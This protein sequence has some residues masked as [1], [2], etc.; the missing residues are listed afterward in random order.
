M[1][2]RLFTGIGNTVVD[3]CR[4]YTLTCYWSWFIA[5]QL[6]LPELGFFQTFGIVLGLDLVLK[7][8]LNH[9]VVTTDDNVREADN[10]D[11]GR[12]LFVGFFVTV[13]FLILGYVLSLLQ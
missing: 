11:V 8:D 3:G 10:D 13:V 1:A 7:G 6:A 12:G 2:N 9:Y 5:S 4:A